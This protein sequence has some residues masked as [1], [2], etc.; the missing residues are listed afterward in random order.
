MK[1]LKVNYSVAGSGSS[2]GSGSKLKFKT[3]PSNPARAVSRLARVVVVP[4][5]FT[6]PSAF[7]VMG[8]GKGNST[9]D[10]GCVMFT[11]T[12]VVA[13]LAV[14]EEVALFSK[15]KEEIFIC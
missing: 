1:Y 6:V 12:L 14:L 11:L 4:P 10:V 15:P 3:Y 9:V 5:I 2:S 7:R 8:M 13:A